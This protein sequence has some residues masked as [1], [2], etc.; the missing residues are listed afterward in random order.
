MCFVILVVSVVIN[1]FIIFIIG[2][3]DVV[4]DLRNVIRCFVKNSYD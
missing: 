4:I 2:R 3:R 1:I